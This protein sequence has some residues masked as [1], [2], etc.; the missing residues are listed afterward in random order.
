MLEHD[1]G[2]EL[3]CKPMHYYT[4]I[5]YILRRTTRYVNKTKINYRLQTLSFCKLVLITSVKIS[6][7]LTM[8]YHQLMLIILFTYNYHRGNRFKN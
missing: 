6:D 2:L 1:L 5:A 8:I 4:Y 3:V 7:K